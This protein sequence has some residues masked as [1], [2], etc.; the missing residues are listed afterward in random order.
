MPFPFLSSAKKALA[1]PVAVHEIFIGL[2]EPVI[3]KLTPLAALVREKPLPDKSIMIGLQSV[4][5]V[6]PPVWFVPKPLLGPVGVHVPGGGG[7]GG[8]LQPCG[9]SNRERRGA[10]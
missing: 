2:P 4:S 9:S 3:S 8:G 1:A 7:G 10:Y 5:S 6:P